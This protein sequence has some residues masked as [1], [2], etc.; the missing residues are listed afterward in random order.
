MPKNNNNK[1]VGNFNWLYIK[2]GLERLGSLSLGLL[3]AGKRPALASNEDGTQ[4]R[5]AAFKLDRFPS[6]FAHVLPRRRLSITF[7]LSDD[8]LFTC[9]HFH[10]TAG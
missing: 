1:S 7:P 6:P 3:V 9:F 2:C 8:V 4:R 10:A 5:P